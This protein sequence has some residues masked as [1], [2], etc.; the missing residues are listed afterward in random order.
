MRRRQINVFRV[1]F[2]S[3]GYIVI[4]KIPGWPT[5]GKLSELMADWMM[6]LSHWMDHKK[7]EWKSKGEFDTF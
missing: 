2:E 4:M 3:G 6:K 1:T 7:L 5:F